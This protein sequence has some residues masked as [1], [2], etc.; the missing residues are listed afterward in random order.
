LALMLGLP[1]L[2]S[3]TVLPSSITE[4]TVLTAAGNPYTGATTVQSGVTLSVEAGV[5]FT[6]TSG[7]ALKVEG[8]L[9]ADGTAE[10]PIVFSSTAN[11]TT[12]AFEPGSGASVLDHVEVING[13]RAGGAGV[14]P[15]PAVTVEKASPTITSSTFR[16]SNFTS[17]GVSEGGSPEIA[18]NEFLE[19][20]GASSAAAIR[21]NVISGTGDVNI[22]DNFIEGG[23]SGIVV[24]ASGSVTGTSLAGNTIVGT[25]ATAPLNF[26]GPAIPANVTENTLVGNEADL[27]EVSGTVAA[28]S[29]WN[30]GGTKIRLGTVTIPAEVTLDVS[31][32][33]FFT[34][35]G[36]GNG[37]TVKGTLDADGTAEHPIVFSS[38]VARTMFA[39]EPGSGASVLDHVEVIN[40]GRAG[41]AGVTPEPAVT[42]EKASPT[43]TS[44]TFRSSNFTSI[45][46]SEGGSPEIANNEF[47]ENS[48]ASSAA[49]IRFNVISGTGDVNIHD[50]FIEGG[51]SGIVVSA[52]GSVTGTSLA[53]NTIVG[54]N[55]TAPLNF[56]GPA[57]PAN[58]TENTLVGN[59]A[60][61]IEVS[62]TVAASSTWNDGG[63]K[64]RLGTVTIPAEVT[65]DVSPGLFFTHA[66]S[67]NGFTVKGTLDADGTAEHPI[68]FSSAVARTMFAFEP[69]SGA[70]VLDHVEVIRGGSTACC[71]TRA[72]VA[73]KKAAPTITNSSFRE[74]RHY[75]IKI[76]ESGSPKIEWNRFR[77]NEKGISYSGIGKL[78]AP[79]NDWG[80][81]S[82]P[83]PAGCGDSV[84]NVEWK[85]AAQ[86][87]EPNGHCRG[88]DS[89][90]PEDGDP[91][92]LASGDLTYSHR[93]LL[94]TNKG[95]LPLEFNRS[96]NSGQAADT[97]LGPGWSQTALAS[98][99]ELTSGAV[100]VVRQDGRQDIF[101]PTESGYKAPSGV[102]STL[103]K[104]EGAFRLTT[105]ENTVYQFGPSGRITSITDAHGL[106]TTFGYD[107]NAR[108]A[109]ITDPSSQALTFSYGSSNHITKVTDSTGREVKY[110]YSGVGDLATVTDALGGVTEYTYDS[111]HCL[112]TIKDPRGNVILT[113]T[114]DG[115]GRVVEQRDGLE[116]LWKLEYNEGATVVVE[117]EGGEITYGFD[118]QDRVVSEEDQLG[119][120]TTTS[121]DASGHV[122]E[123]VK[124]GGAKWQFGHDAAGNL[125]SV[126]DPEEGERSYEYDPQNR[127]TS[128]TDE[129]EETWSYEWDEANDLVKVTDPAEGETTF[130][131]DAAGLPLTV[132]DPNENTTT[133][134]YDARGNRL[135]AKDALEHT[136]AF[137]YNTRNQLTS[138]TAPGLKAETYGRNALGD[139]LSKTTPEGDKTE[140]TYD[141]N[142]LLTKVTDPAEGVWE[143]ER[144]AMERA[145]A[146]LD[147]FEQKSAISY[148]GN[149][150]PVKVTDRRGMETTYGYDLANQLTQIVGPEGGDWEFGYDARGNRI[151][152]V[153]PR[154]NASTYEFD[155]LDRMTDVAEPLAATTSYEYDPA[156]NLV[157]FT[158]PR[159]NTTELTHDQLGR[160]TAINQPLEKV[161]TFT[162]DGVGNRLTRTTAA[163]TLEFHYNAANRLEEISDGE[164]TLR[165]FGYDP[166]GRL[167]GA[168]D[169]Q[170]DE[171]E[172]GYDDDGR[173]VSI[174]DGRGQAMAREYDSRGNVVEQTDGRGTLEYEF[175]KLNRMVE[176]TDPQGK[177][178]GFDY[179]PEGNLT[180][181]ELPNGVVTTNEFDNAGRLA[182]MTSAKGEA[183]LESLG[184]EYDPNGN[185]I[186]QVDRLSQETSY[187]Y[188]ALNRLIGFDP[189]GEGSTGYDYD[190]A[191][192][193]TE[194][195]ATTYGFNN[196][197]QLTSASNGTTYDY[198]DAGRLVEAAQGEASTTFEWNLLDELTSVETGSQEIDFAYDA[199][200]RQVLRDDGSTIRPTHYGDLSDRPILDTDAEGA[201]MVS[202]V[203]GPSGLVEQ[204][205]GEAT[206]FP[207]RDAHG[208]ITTLVDGEGEVASRQTYGPWGEHL[209]GPNLEM[210]WL[211]S[212]QRRS[213]PATGLV[214]MGIRSY[215]PTL[216]AFLTEDPVL[217]HVGMGMTV[218][219]YLYTL[220][221]PLNRYDLNGRDVCAFGGCVGP[222]DVVAI[223]EDVEGGLGIAQEGVSAV[224]SA[225][226]AAM[227]DAWDGTAVSRTWVAD[228]SRAF[229]K[230]YGETLEN[231]YTFAGGNWEQCRNGAAA[232][233]A[234]GAVIGSFFPVVGTGAGAIGGG[235]LGCAGT[236]GVKVGIEEIYGD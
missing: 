167:I 187:E 145:T 68:V 123:I 50:N 76:T 131:H 56:S 103:T 5:E 179:D 4:N 218:D 100:L 53:G 150:R 221:N 134:T 27:I 37:F 174:D 60:D 79:N 52:S 24:S 210:G 30:D 175:D 227:E 135:T 14:T 9:D 162:Y 188:D 183:T 234:S 152:V 40:G 205:S 181:A 222:D 80:C 25:N 154:E 219:R 144:N 209:S 177:V 105:L 146:Y 148:D 203:Q 32:G 33:L 98:V 233:T 224:G 70:S 58:V 158:D 47:L 223:A 236:V 153:D 84:S 156:S 213:D 26:S 51:N 91:V 165:V 66:G 96:Y 1:T 93:D 199:L 36:S 142:G 138:K 202:Y 133:F 157:G 124:P 2:A 171:I 13:G 34:H 54:T 193:R 111:A 189:P 140:Y 63:T 141:A 83:K 191:G 31:P 94:L 217:G 132:T 155:L 211:G 143:I 29:T 75:A 231:I 109:T 62:G 207:L 121:Y 97:G 19:N 129:R 230:E 49:A 163:G 55:A 28:S 128:F 190:L 149:L 71:E 112:K 61:L 48:G 82:G 11:R 7:P 108:L 118:A 122:D 201:P 90:C 147:P 164:A 59:E 46:V 125:T 8:T 20:S 78:V 117:P 214:Q 215:D 22:H 101:H 12:I 151:E 10:D 176:L 139:L 192:N 113:N 35:A 130:T 178:L 89:Q 216:G 235:V 43:I 170:A 197:N 225:A 126:I 104:V 106:K 74:A 99:T 136:T 229:W 114:Y 200:G 107:G 168:T 44:S 18:N 120:V 198:D 81:A 69:G 160:L 86:L 88:E 208:D 195:G 110:T 226:G 77:K 116:N 85:P 39:F 161:T 87:P 137:E 186:G 65:L 173:V 72:A 64:I 42:V 159:E 21:F 212:Q 127:L 45:G 16:S 115:Q 228:R 38:A 57:I 119:H 17:I 194:A 172:V 67:G 92:S 6:P 220:S 206:S 73:I 185:R 196:L 184:Y 232:G 95:E 180:K 166:A 23:N 41:G 182:E 102:T 204:R 15:E 169:A 3:A